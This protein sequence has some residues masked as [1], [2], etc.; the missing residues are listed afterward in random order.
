MT[1]TGFGLFPMVVRPVKDIMRSDRFPASQPAGTGRPDYPSPD[2]GASGEKSSHISARELLMRVGSDPARFIPMSPF[3][4]EGRMQTGIWCRE[5]ELA[6]QRRGLVRSGSSPGVA[7]YVLP[8][9]A[10]GPRCT[11]GHHMGQDGAVRVGCYLGADIKPDPWGGWSDVDAVA[12]EVVY[13]LRGAL[14]AKRE[15]RPARKA[16]MEQLAV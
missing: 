15:S 4:R 6:L 3:Q 14:A 12:D 10:R 7:Y 13:R 5:V 1:Q 9:A 16:E 8:D 2:P 11:V